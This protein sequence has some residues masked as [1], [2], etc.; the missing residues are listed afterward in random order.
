MLESKR[1]SWINIHKIINK[2]RPSAQ[3]SPALWKFSYTFDHYV[4]IS[5]SSSFQEYIN[6][7]YVCC[8]L[9]LISLRLKTI[10]GIK[11]GTY[12]FLL[13]HFF[14]CLWFMMGCP[15][16]IIVDSSIGHFNGS[17]IAIDNNT[18][19]NISVLLIEDCRL[20]SWAMHDGRDMGIVVV[21]FFSFR[22]L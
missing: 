16:N 18:S 11:F 13:T 14:A 6:H 19:A 1:L 5:H 17:L 10:R 3:A 2:K 15:K 21:L 20:D 22:F 12:M 7:L 8:L 4:K 9:L